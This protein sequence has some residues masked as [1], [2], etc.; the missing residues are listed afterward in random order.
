M[1]DR[2]VILPVPEPDMLRAN[3]IKFMLAK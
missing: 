3:D 2:H 1:Q